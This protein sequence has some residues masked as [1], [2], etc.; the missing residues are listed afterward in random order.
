MAQTP[1]LPFAEVLE[2]STVERVLEQEGGRGRDCVFTPL[3]TLRCLLSQAIDPDGSCQQAVDRLLAER[4]AQDLPE[5][6]ANTGAYCQARQRLP[7]GV[8]KQLTRRVGQGLLL[9]A[10]FAWL[11]KGRDVKVADGTTVSLPDTPANQQA[12]PQAGTQKVGVGFPLLRL[13]VL[14]ALAVGTVVEAALGRY[15]GK[16]TGEPALLRTLHETLF[17]DDV[18]LGD[19]YYC[20]YFEIALLQR[21]R[22]DAVFRLH[23]RRR[24]DFRRGR[25]LGPND[26]VVEWHKPARPAWLDEE[27]YQSLPDT[28]TLREVRIR[29]A[30]PGQRTKVIVVA[31][32]L[33]DAEAFSRTDLTD[34]YR[35]RWQAELNLRSLKTVMQMDVLRAK[36]PEMV[37]KELWAHLLAYNLIRTVMAQAAQTQGLRPEDI[38]FKGALQTV[39]TFAPYL[40]M[41]E[42]EDLAEWSRRLLEAIA[43]HRVGQRPNRY[44]PR[45]RKRRPK[46]YGLLNESR[47]QAR[48]RLTAGACR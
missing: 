33:L 30:Q 45:K 5:V 16:E 19:R 38:S 35:A 42:R 31:T 4:A 41:A 25:R 7:E 37:R 34:L 11:W 24:A 6:S 27:T 3:V 39:N 48:E 26:H 21:R 46:P 43:Q 10:P 1:G 9:E 17:E 23:Q 36:T 2:A 28:L 15:Q 12:Y 40:L 22:V 18:L 29:V 14:F 44:E 47:A 8:V 32:T 20:S 13:V